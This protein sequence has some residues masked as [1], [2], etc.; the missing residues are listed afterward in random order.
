MVGTRF[1][2]KKWE[3]TPV[4]RKLIEEDT[5][6][7]VDAAHKYLHYTYG[8]RVLLTFSRRM[9]KGSTCLKR[10]FE[11]FILQNYKECR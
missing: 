8:R 7:A 1:G 10:V 3:D 4:N 5:Q 9:A 6:E 2:S 11:G